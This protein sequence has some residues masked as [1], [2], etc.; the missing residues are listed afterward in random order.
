MEKTLKIPLTT[1]TERLGRALNHSIGMNHMAVLMHG[2]RK[3]RPHE[4]PSFSTLAMRK[5]NDGF[6]W[7]TSYEAEDLSRYAG[8]DLTQD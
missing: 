4:A 6:P 5:K 8:Y 3:H 1:I 7:L 2:W